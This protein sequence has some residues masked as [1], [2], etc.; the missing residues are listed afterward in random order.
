[1][2][3]TLNP[4]ITV[5]NRQIENFPFLQKVKGF[6]NARIG[7]HRGKFA[8]SMIDNIVGEQGRERFLAAQ[9][10]PTEIAVSKEADQP[11]VITDDA[12]DAEAVCRHALKRFLDQGAGAHDRDRL[13]RQ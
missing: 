2:D 11:L 13:R 10:Q 8:A 3:Q 6:F 1:M 5:E 4:A 12:G 9:Q 7:A